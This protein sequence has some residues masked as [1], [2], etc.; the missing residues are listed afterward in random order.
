[1]KAS[2][3]CLPLLFVQI[4]ATILNERTIRAYNEIYPRCFDKTAVQ[5]IS[6]VQEEPSLFSKKMRVVLKPK[7]RCSFFGGGDTMLSWD[8]VDDPKISNQVWT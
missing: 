7:A 2:F 4:Y 5:A 6:D 3:Y 8:P 1:M